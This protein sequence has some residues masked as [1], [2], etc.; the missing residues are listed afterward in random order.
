MPHTAFRCPDPYMWSEVPG[1]WGLLS[2]EVPIDKCLECALTRRD[3]ACPYDYADLKL[4]VEEGY[5]EQFSPSRF[6][7][8]DREQYLR[9]TTDFSTDPAEQSARVRGTRAHAV[10][11]I[12]DDPGVI[13]EKR[14]YRPLM[15]DGEQ[16][17]IGVKPNKVY[18][19]LA[20]ISDLKTWKYLPVKDGQ[21]VDQEVKEENRIQLSIGAWAW[22]RPC[23]KDVDGYGN[24]DYFAI[25]P[26]HIDHGQII[27]QDGT[28]QLRQAEISLI[29][30]DQLE[31]LMAQRV[32]ELRKVYAGEE[33]GY[34]DED[35][36]WRCKTCPVRPQCGIELPKR[37]PAKKPCRSRK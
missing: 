25:E 4:R 2:Q 28:K 3:R 18:P 33:P 10:V 13:S 24:N 9:A 21:P 35:K 27:I 36:R 30:D 8:C 29:P 1:S 22:E 32:R 5:T 19:E 37:K 11:E 34:C 23:R 17:W 31:E 15:V 14:I 20:E 7:G 6:N 16:A 26:I 12:T